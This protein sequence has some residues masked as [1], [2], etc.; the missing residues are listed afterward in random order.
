M[1]FSAEVKAELVAI[2]ATGCCQLAECYGMLLC[3]HT[4][5][6][7]SI[8]LLTEHEVVA[9]HF[10]RLLRLC[11]DVRAIQTVRGEK[12]KRFMV[13]VENPID[14]KKIRIAL[15]VLHA[16]D[17]LNFDIVRRECCAGAFL[18]G[19][20]LS[21]GSVNA[22]EKG[23]HA[24]FLVGSSSIADALDAVL[25]ERHMQARRAQRGKAYVLY[26][27][28]SD[29]IEDLLTVMSATNHTLELMHA[30]IYKDVRNKIN[31]IKN[32]ETANILKTVD[33]A[34]EQRQAIEK[35]EKSGKFESL[36]PELL[37]VAQLRKEN[38]EASL[39]E[40][41]ALSEEPITRSGLNHRLKRLLMLAN[42]DK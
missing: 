23:Y 19:A 8:S 10:A 6:D 38:P 22:P 33:A 18:R 32:C 30:K 14:R 41:V 31:R 36:P 34:I 11:F 1:S 39:S 7:R 42:T 20:F 13:A 35:L 27:K 28:E 2:R 12:R 15:G 16:S 29:R 26:F 5:S 3:G 40:L 21:C 24:E 37:A 9:S 4:F 25:A 17:G